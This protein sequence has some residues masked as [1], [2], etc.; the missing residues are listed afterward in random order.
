MKH[1]VVVMLFLLRG[2][3]VANAEDQMAQSANIWHKIIF[4]TFLEHIL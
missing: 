2:G 1:G 3:A 4:V